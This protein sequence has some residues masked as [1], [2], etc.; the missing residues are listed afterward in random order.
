M[1][2]YDYFTDIA[3]SITINNTYAESQD[4]GADEVSDGKD[5]S[6]GGMG[7]AQQRGTGA[8]K[9]GASTSSPASGTDEESSSEKEANDADA[10]KQKAKV[11]DQEPAAGHKP[12]DGGEGSGQKGAEASGPHG[13]PVKAG[14]YAEDDEDDEE[15]ADEEEEEEEDE[16]EDIKQ[17]LEEECMRTKQ[18]APAKHHYDE[19]SERVTEQHETHGKAHEDCV[20]EFFHLMHCAT[21]CAAPKLFKQLRW[22]NDLIHFPNSTQHQLGAFLFSEEGLHLSSYRYNLGGDGGN[23]SQQVV[24]VGSRVE[25]FLLRNGTYDWSRDHAGISFLKMAQQ[26]AVPYITYFINAAPSHI[27]TNGAACGWNMTAPAVPAFA[28][29]IATVLSYWKTHGVDIKYISPMNEPDNNRAD[30]G[31]EGMLVAPSLRSSVF[32]A[33]RSALNGSPA[34]PVGIIGDETS[35]ITT[36]ALPEDPLW[37]P[38]SASTLTN[39]AVHNYDYPSDASLSQYYA[40]LLNLTNNRPPPVKFTE[41]CCSTNAG[42]GSGV[43]GAQY[44][45]TMANALIVARYIWQYLTLAHAESF[46]WWTAVTNLPCSP[47]VDGEQCATQ[48]NASSGYNSGL[49]YIDGAYNETG[50]YRVWTTKRAWM[51]KHFAHF[52]RPG[53]VRLDVGQGQLPFG[54]DAVASTRGGGGGEGVQR[55][56]VLFMNNQTSAFNLTFQAPGRYAKLTRVVQTT[57]EADWKDVGALP[58]VRKGV[59]GVEVPGVSFVTLVFTQ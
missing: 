36:Q 14:A 26:Y 11:A 30:C 1:G 47:S 24:T 42:S 32:A 3:S 57:E 25:S 28:T 16:P 20:E 56:S 10:E 7:T 45:P 37:L 2:W 41:T 58:V 12:G 50:D 35:Q 9:G 31:Q 52:H 4:L 13:G 22:P 8:T 38:A 17:K 18:C 53:S 5:V 59:V 51:M 34:A 15:A 49:V 39:I 23:D 55:W 46:D 33:I 21:N 29:Y 19:C 48:F 40:S 27:A 43:F 6:Q 44:D 54:V